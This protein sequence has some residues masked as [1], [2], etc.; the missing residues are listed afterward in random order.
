MTVAGSTRR[1]NRG[2]G[3]SYTLD[4]QHVAGVT[5][6]LS[7]G[8]AK[9]AL[10][11]WAGRTTAGYAIDHWA[12][13]AELQLSERLRRLE[14]ARFDAR[15]TAAVRGTAVHQLAQRLAA[16]EEIDVPEELVGHVDAYLRFT[17]EW[18]PREILVEAPIFSRQFR[19]AGTLDLVADLA[20]GRRW[21]LDWK[22]AGSGVFPDNALQLAAYR[23]ADFYLDP[24]GIER[25]LPRIDRAGV[26]WLRAD[27]YDLVPVNAGADAFELFGHVQE[28]ARFA[29]DDRG[30]WVG[31]ALP[32]PQEQAA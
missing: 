24:E 20:D 10:I 27:G 7:R 26:V 21:L 23:Y 3:H 6:I 2:R 9:P 18:R 15:D 5:T 11:D 29:D 14:R 32:A 1:V 12:E 13:L 25:P 19:Y 28:L 4:G 17:E 31:E 30:V 16:G 22:T 8:L